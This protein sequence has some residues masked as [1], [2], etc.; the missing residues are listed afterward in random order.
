MRLCAEYSYRDRLPGTEVA[1]RPIFPVNNEM[2]RRLSVPKRLEASNVSVRQQEVRSGKE[3]A[4]AHR[5][6]RYSYVP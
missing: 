3:K 5:Q 1:D 2:P 6:Q 4:A